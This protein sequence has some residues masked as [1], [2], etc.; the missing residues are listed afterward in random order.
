MS[1][2][3]SSEEWKAARDILEGTGIKVINDCSALHTSVYVSFDKM[4]ISAAPAWESP[5]LH[6][7][8]PGYLKLLNAIQDFLFWSTVKSIADT[9]D[10]F[11]KIRLDVSSIAMCMEITEWSELSVFSNSKA[12]V[13]YAEGIM[14]FTSMKPYNDRELEVCI[15]SKFPLIAVN[16]KVVYSNAE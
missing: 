6:T 2:L 8:L 11:S 10:R 4:T 16:A 7:I 5:E 13:E 14:T 15:T 12:K 9:R 3:I 1:F